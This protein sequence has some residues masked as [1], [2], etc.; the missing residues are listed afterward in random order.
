MHDS[1]TC[2]IRFDRDA[3]SRF[4]SCEVCQGQPPDSC[5]VKDDLPRGAA[6]AMAKKLEG[7]FTMAGEMIEA[8]KL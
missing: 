4:F 5:D 3:N 1:C 6:R 2:D 8:M 7:C